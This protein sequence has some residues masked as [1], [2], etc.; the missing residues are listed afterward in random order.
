MFLM[1]A[2]KK[3]FS[4]KEIQRQLSM[5]RYESVWTMVHKF[6]KAMGKLDDRYTFEDMI[7]MD[8]G[9]FIIE[10]SEYDYKT[11]KAGGGSKTKA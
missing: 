3:G 2:T 8:E 9:Y 6:R 1:T 7:E 10:A 5:K 11:P 4:T